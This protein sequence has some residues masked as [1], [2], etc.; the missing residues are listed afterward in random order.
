MEDHQETRNPLLRNS[1]CHQIELFF[2]HNRN[3]THSVFNLPP[4]FHSY[5]SRRDHQYG[6]GSTNQQKPIYFLGLPKLK[7]KSLNKKNSIGLKNYHN[8]SLL[9]MVVYLQ[10]NKITIQVTNHWWKLR[11]SQILDHFNRLFTQTLL[12]TREF[13]KTSKFE[14]DML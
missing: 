9:Y 2:S 3:L 7:I 6:N 5:I 12:R 10:I 14:V 4:I 11:N 13:N 8:P 1:R